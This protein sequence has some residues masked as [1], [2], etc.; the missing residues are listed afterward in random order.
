[1]R[2]TIVISVLCLASLA[3]SGWSQQADGGLEGRVLDGDGKP[4][5]YVNVTVSGNSATLS[6]VAKF[7]FVLLLLLMQSPSA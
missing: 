2:H 1:M 5:A 4:L 6:G 7:Q 3:T